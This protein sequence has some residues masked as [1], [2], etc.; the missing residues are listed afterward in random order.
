MDP[1]MSTSTKIELMNKLRL[2][3]QN[4]GRKHRSKLITQAVDL[5][6]LTCFPKDG[7][8]KSRVL[9]IKGSA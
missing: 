6:G 3:Y 7:H 8:R 5:M 2:R 9:L 4:A 1:T